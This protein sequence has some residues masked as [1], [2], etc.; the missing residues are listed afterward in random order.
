[1]VINELGILNILH[2]GDMTVEPAELFEFNFRKGIT[3]YNTQSMYIIWI[4][5][6]LDITRANSST[7]CEKSVLEITKEATYFVFCPALLSD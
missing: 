4:L 6:I 3:F 1:M 2:Q 5:K 7:G